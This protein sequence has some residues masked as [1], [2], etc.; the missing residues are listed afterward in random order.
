MHIEKEQPLFN[1]I[2]QIKFKIFRENYWNLIFSEN[3][4]LLGEENQ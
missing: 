3:I 2:P 4:G 1:T